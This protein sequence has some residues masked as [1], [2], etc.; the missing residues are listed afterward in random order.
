MTPAIGLPIARRNNWNAPREPRLGVMLHYDASTSDRG[1]VQWLM[2]DPRCKVSYNYLVLDNGEVVTVAPVTARAWHAGIC[3][4]SDPGRLPYRDANSAFWGVSI[5]A[6]SGDV[7]TLAAKVAVARVCTELML[8]MGWDL[9]STF[10][11][12]GHDT[13]AWPRGRKIDPEGPDPLRP[14]L[15]VTEIRRM[16]ATG[17]LAPDVLNG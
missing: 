7:A 6:G 4:S 15:S 11:I 2:H 9:S 12:V 1:A 5:A 3:R 13:E 17:A 10:R 14:V 16:V 8:S